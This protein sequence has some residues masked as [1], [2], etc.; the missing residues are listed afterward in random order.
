MSN[1][2]RYTRV[3][4]FEK[5]RKNTKA[6]SV[7]LLLGGLLIVVLVGFWIFGG[8]DEEEA[9][10]DENNNE[11]TE[12]SI[13]EEDNEEED[14]DSSEDNNATEDGAD[15]EQTENTYES[16]TETN[17]E[18][19]HEEDIE[20]EEADPV[21]DD[22][23]VIDAYTG[24]WQPVGTEQEGPHTTQFVVDSQD[25]MEME[26]AIRLA[27]GLVEENMI[28]WFIGNGGEQK[29]IGTVSNSANTEYYRVYLTW[30]D[31]EGWK[32]TLVE[33]LQENDKD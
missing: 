13:I 26:K 32:P 17:E 20:T 23:N 29:A 3:N 27:T 22:E 18:N 8:N 31:H 11:E 1:F 6:I 5:R 7:L 12:S 14:S 25:W 10:N 2:D 24:N 21:S 33:V 4:K 30:V 9:S 16:N 28:T 19:T 15:E